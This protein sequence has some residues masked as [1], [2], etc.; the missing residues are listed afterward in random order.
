MMITQPTII[1]EVRE[2]R[3]VS[4]SPVASFLGQVEKSEYKLRLNVTVYSL[5]MTLRFY[6]QWRG[7]SP[8]FILTP[9][10]ILISELT[11]AQANILCSIYNTFLYYINFKVNSKVNFDDHTVYERKILPIN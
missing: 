10:D 4:L 1:D 11:E 2:K 7:F 3:F 6:V 5:H 9:T 8:S